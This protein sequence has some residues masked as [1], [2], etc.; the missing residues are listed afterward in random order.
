MAAAAV[1]PLLDEGTASLAHGSLLAVEE[2]R[3]ENGLAMLA[4]A[5]GR[6]PP[7]GSEMGCVV[8]AGVAQ[9]SLEAAEP[10]AKSSRLYSMTP[11]QE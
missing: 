5:V 9:G 1:D 8:G 6:D 7:H 3:G 2:G 11:L 4:A 10:P